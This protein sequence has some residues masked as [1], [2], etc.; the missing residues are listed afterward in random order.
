VNTDGSGHGDQ[1]PVICRLLGVQPGEFTAGKRGFAARFPAVCAV[2]FGGE[3][4][5]RL[6]LSERASGVH[7]QAAAR[8]LR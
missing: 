2:R 1:N 3:G 8:P 6:S 5:P 4:D 7:A